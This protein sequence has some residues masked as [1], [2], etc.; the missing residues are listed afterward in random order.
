M[1]EGFSWDYLLPLARGAMSTIALC[2]VSGTL[3]SV[4]GLILGLAQTSPSRAARWISGIYVNAVR[5]VPLLVIIFFIYFGI[6]LVW[7][8]FDLSTFLTG[9]IALTGFAAAYIAEIFRGSIEAVPR[10]QSEAADALGLNYSS[11]YRFVILP[12]A[13]KIAIPP[14]ISFLLAL[15]KDSSLITVIGFVE[16]TK[17]GTIVSNLTGDPMTTYLI[18]AAF[19]F[20]I[21]YGISELGRRYEKRVG[22]RSNPLKEQL[23]V[24]L[25]IGRT[26]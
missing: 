5:G 14:G 19:Y 6:P 10:G 21:C 26:R 13:L 7:P 4:L 20:V 11:K 12:Q 2:V 17:A 23:P 24:R 3:G 16:L 9:V 8:S 22:I 1:F 15:I 25:K 18:V